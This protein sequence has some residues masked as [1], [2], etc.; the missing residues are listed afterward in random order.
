MAEP[1]QI[2]LLDFWA[3]WCGPCKIMEP[4]LNQIE[5]EYQGKVTLRKCNVDDDAYSSL[6][7]KYQIMSI[8]TY[9]LLVGGEVE[10]S[11]IGV[12]PKETIQRHIDTVLAKVAG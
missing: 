2:E 9:I 8:P 7:D 4:V 1:P 6:V 10:T 12:T 3:V 11:F 5:S